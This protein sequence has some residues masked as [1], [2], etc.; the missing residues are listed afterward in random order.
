MVVSETLH[1]CQ[2]ES[3][4]LCEQEIVQAV[5]TPAWMPTAPAST[6]TAPASVT[7]VWQVEVQETYTSVGAG[8]L[9]QGTPDR[10]S[11]G[12]SF[13]GLVSNMSLA[14]KPSIEVEMG[15]VLAMNMFGFMC[16]EQVMIKMRPASR[17]VTWTEEG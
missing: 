12:P 5:Q 16:K 2:H 4:V 7:H 10:S 1:F 13:P 14:C 3:L 15:D 6:P 17:Q 11:A 8:G 9:K